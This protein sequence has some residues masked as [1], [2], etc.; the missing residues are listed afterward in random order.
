MNARQ[1]ASA[2]EADIRVGRIS[3]KVQAEIVRCVA[4]VHAGDDSLPGRTEKLLLR[5]AKRPGKAKT[6]G[7]TDYQ[8]RVADAANTAVAFAKFNQSDRDLAAQ[9]MAEKFGVGVGAVYRAIDQK[10][11][12]MN[13]LR[14]KRQ[15]TPGINRSG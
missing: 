3:A 6:A 8:I 7:P 12:V 11:K 4:I 5:H 14:K 9:K 2:I 13:A 1:L 10:D 15:N